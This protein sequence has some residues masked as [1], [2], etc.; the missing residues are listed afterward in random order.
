[1]QYIAKSAHLIGRYL[2]QGTFRSQLQVAVSLFE[3]AAT[4]VDRANKEMV[5]QLKLLAHS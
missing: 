4:P 5:A 2:C 1:M 3:S